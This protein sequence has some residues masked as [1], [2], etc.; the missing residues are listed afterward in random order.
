MA[1]YYNQ[2]KDLV[3]NAEWLGSDIG[4]NSERVDANVQEIAADPDMPTEAE[5][6][7]ARARAKDEYL[8]VAFLLNSDKRQYGDLIWTI[9]N[10]YTRGTNTYP[11]TLSAAY[12]YIINYQYQKLHYLV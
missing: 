5:W 8:A 9:E 7:Q 12:D 2:F 1:E 11:M 4:L 10:E 6:E 3:S